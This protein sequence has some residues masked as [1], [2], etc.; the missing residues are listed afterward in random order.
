[1]GYPS[2]IPSADLSF[3]LLRGYKE[4][5]KTINEALSPGARKFFVQI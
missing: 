5:I 1:M 2:Q 4:S 3:G